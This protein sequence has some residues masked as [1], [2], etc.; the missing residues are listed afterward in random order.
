ML[1]LITY[2]LAKPKAQLEEQQK[3]NYNP[4]HEAIEQCGDDCYNILGSVWLVHTDKTPD[5]CYK[6]IVPNM[7]EEDELFIVDITE[8]ENRHN[9]SFD[10]VT[11]WIIK[12]D[13]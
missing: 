12:N 7:E 2:D 10:D 3:R 6:I 13:N 9:L 11:M 8:K 4:V 1:L 5:E